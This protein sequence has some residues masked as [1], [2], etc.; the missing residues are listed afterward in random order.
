LKAAAKDG[1]GGATLGGLRDGRG[2]GDRVRGAGAGD[3]AT[4]TGRRGEA[5]PL[6]SRGMI[7]S[8]LF[9]CWPARR[10]G[11]MDGADGLGDEAAVGSARNECV[12]KPGPLAKGVDGLAR[13][14]P[15]LATLS[16]F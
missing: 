11:M 9:I 8:T 10:Y 12:T 13:R 6:R 1:C 14:R 4:R 2:A 7:Y 5:E 16:T 15:F 3:L